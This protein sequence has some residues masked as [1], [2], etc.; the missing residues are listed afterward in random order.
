MNNIPLGAKAKDIV[1]GFSGIVT[2]KVSYLTGCD[3][4]L[5]QPPMK[6]GDLKDARWFDVNRCERDGDEA[7]IVLDT[8]KDQGAC[9]SAPVK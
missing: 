2:G 6:D 1:T 4:L 8:S 9:E 3:Q 5:V 7:P